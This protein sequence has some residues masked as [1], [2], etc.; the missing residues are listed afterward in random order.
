MEV[1]WQDHDLANFHAEHDLLED[2]VMDVEMSV[3]GAHIMI[4]SLKEEI[5]DLNDSVANCQEHCPVLHIFLCFPLFLL[6]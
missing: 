3:K 2:R 5:W 1:E 4:A 6:P